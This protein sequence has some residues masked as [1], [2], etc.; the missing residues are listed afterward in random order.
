M[1]DPCAIGRAAVEAQGSGGGQ[2]GDSQL[3]LR[4]RGTAVKKAYA[5]GSCA[6]LGSNLG[7]PF[8][9]ERR[10]GEPSR[11]KIR[12]SQKQ[13]QATTPLSRREAKSKSHDK[14]WFVITENEQGAVQI[15]DSQYKTEAQP[16]PRGRSTFLKPIEAPDDL[17]P[18]ADW[19]TRPIVTDRHDGRVVL[20][21][22]ANVNFGSSWTVVDGVLQE[23]SEHLSEELLVAGNLAG[24]FCE[25]VENLMPGVSR[26]RPI[27]IDNVT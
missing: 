21:C 4:L 12:L 5:A 25:V 14:T 13:K 17:I 22:E 18:L 6:R 19:N 1:I 11:R 20:P 3:R 7:R 27:D 15:S 16:G 23:V 9:A 2:R 24:R 10:T 26:D 8:S